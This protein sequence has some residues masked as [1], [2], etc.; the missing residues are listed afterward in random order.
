MKK[1]IYILIFLLPL[2]IQAQTPWVK[3][4]PEDYTWKYVGNPGLSSSWAYYTSL[5]ISPS[6]QPYLAFED[7]GNYN[8]VTVMKYDGTNWVNVGVAGFSVSNAEYISLAISPTDGQPYVAFQDWPGN[9]YK[10][11]VMKF[12][13]VSWDY[14]GSAGFSAGKAEYT[15]LA[16]SPSG[17]PYV[18]YVDYGNSKKSTVM[19]F[20]GTNWLNVGN[21][22]F[23]D[24]EVSCTSLAMSQSNEPYIA[25]VD[26]IPYARKATVKRFDGSSWVNVGNSCFSQVNIINTSLALSPSDQP[27]VA[28]NG[29]PDYKATVMKYDGT[30][31]VYVGTAGFSEGIPIWISLAFNPTD[32]QPY[33]AF[34]DFANS[35]NATVMRFDG[36]NWDY[37]GLKGFSAGYVN[38]PSLAVSPSG[39]PYVAYQDNGNFKKASVMKFDSVFVGIN[40][41]EH[42]L[43]S[44][45]PDPVTTKLTIDLKNLPGII[46]Y[47]EITDIFGKKMT[48]AQSHERKIILDVESYLT[49]IYFV[50]LKTL[51]SVY[52]GKFCKN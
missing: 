5:A 46:D 15:N 7:V 19:K 3:E 25:Y 23:S 33:V 36:T 40:E 47:F 9:S 42:P 39:V 35:G 38:Y 24:T 34:S 51:H 8:R 37:V 2:I 31:W 48:G 43:F 50:R 28:D 30:N 11:T 32:G 13:G 4:S 12:D 41:N 6:G 18:A 21:P 22:G 27:Y 45:Y 29:G 44:I 49:G 14:V 10:A 1:S 26:S 16:F 17:V 52:T 20:D